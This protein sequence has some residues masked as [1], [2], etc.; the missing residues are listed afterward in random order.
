MY[1]ET[2][3]RIRII[4]IL[5]LTTCPTF[6][7]G[8]NSKIV[9]DSIYHNF[10]SYFYNVIQE[11][12]IRYNEKE[13]NMADY[14]DDITNNEFLKESPYY[15][16]LEPYINDIHCTEN[17]LGSID[18]FINDSLIID[19]CFPIWCEEFVHDVRLGK[20][21]Y[22]MYAYNNSN[23]TIEVDSSSR[24]VFYKRLWNVYKAISKKGN[25][26]YDI[27]TY[28]HWMKRH[29]ANYSIIDDSISFLCGCGMPEICLKPEIKSICKDYCIENKC[30]RISF[31]L[32]S[33]HRKTET[34]FLAI[35]QRW[36]PKL[37][38][39][40]I[41]TDGFVR[42]Q[43][44]PW[45]INYL[46]EEDA[47]KYYGNFGYYSKELYPIGWFNVNNHVVTIVKDYISDDILVST[48]TLDGEGISNIVLPND[49]GDG[50]YIRKD[51]HIYLFKSD[52][53]C[54]AISPN[55]VIGSYKTYMGE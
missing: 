31:E 29:W 23:K 34:E 14:R 53:E 42:S 3:K 17:S 15:S 36:F 20:M 44:T 11:I 16:W 43:K 4:V 1:I 41:V 50:F 22:S 35:I 32:L 9:P 46:R 8:Q 40:I 45:Q 51:G 48:F 26:E 39:P 24:N 21:R 12:S 55:G 28:S 49:N 54:Y 52:N 47:E 5:I 33:W 30:A 13:F 38:T 10:M 37:N 18:V 19:N 27:S 6:L 2:M 25:M 7:L